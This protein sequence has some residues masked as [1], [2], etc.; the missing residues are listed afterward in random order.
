MTL[1]SK[2]ARLLKVKEGKEL[3]LQDQDILVK[4]SAAAHKSEHLV[5]TELY[6]QLKHEVRAGL[7]GS[8]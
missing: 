4:I 6:R 3:K 8:K 1:V 7:A 5:L 2:F